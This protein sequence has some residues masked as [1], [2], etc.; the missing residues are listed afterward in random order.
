[1]FFRDKSNNVETLHQ[2]TDTIKGD[3]RYEK[4]L[5]K[6]IRKY[7]QQNYTWHLSETD[8]FF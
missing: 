5:N 1:M 4:V 7:Q 6:P 3:K 2:F 8:E